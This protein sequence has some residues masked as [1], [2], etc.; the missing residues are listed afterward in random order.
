[1]ERE[2]GGYQGCDDDQN[3][4]ISEAK[5]QLLEVLNLHLT[6]L[7]AFFVLF[8]RRKAGGRHRSIIA[9]NVTTS[10]L[11]T[12]AFE[13]GQ[14]AVANK[15]DVFPHGKP[16]LSPGIFFQGLVDLHVCDRRSSC[17]ELVG[18]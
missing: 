5:V 7:L 16:C 2:P 17:R 6:R 4:E 9:Y 3:A 12:C 13:G 1:M 10:P 15:D 8:G 11:S 14:Q 18:F